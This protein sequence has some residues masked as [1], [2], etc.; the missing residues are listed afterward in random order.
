MKPIGT[1]DL[2]TDPFKKHRSPKPFL[3]GFYDGKTIRI[4]KGPNCVRD[5]YKEMRKFSGYIYA[6]NGGKFDF[7][8]LLPYLYK[9]GAE[10]RPI[11]GRAARFILPN[12][13]EFRDSYC[14][15]PVPLKAT[16]GKLEMDYRKLEANVRHKHMD[17]IVTYLKADLLVLHEKVTEFVSEYGFGMTLAGRT[18]DQFK[19]HFNLNP[20]KTNEFYDRKFRQYYYGGRVEFFELGHLRGKFKLIDINSAYPAAMMKD[21]A[22]GTEW[23]DLTRL[24]KTGVEQCFIRFIGESKGGLPWRGEDKSLSFAPRVGEFFVSGW[25]FVAAQKARAV[26][27]DEYISILRPLETRNFSEFVTHFYGMKKRAEKGSSDELF[28]KLILNSSY[29]RFA[30]NSR[31]YRDVQMESAAGEPDENKLFRKQIAKLVTRKFPKLRGDAFK[32]KCA[33]YWRG[34]EG[35]WELTNKFEDVGI[36]VWER[37]SEVKSDAFFNVATA[38][39]I[40]GAVRAF[41]FESLRA[42][43]RPVYCDTDS[44]ICED[45]GKLKLG[46]ELGEWK[47]E[48]ESVTD[49]LWIAAKK[50]YALKIKNG[51][52]PWKLASKGVRLS[53]GEIKKVAEGETIKTTLIAPTFSIFT[54]NS[55]KGNKTDF[56]TRTTR[57]DDKRIRK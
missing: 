11:K 37:P 22:F 14:I 45:T 41:M 52:K 51:K 29:G 17:E 21:H 24:P 1:F 40:T 42:V 54:S 32:E 33:S 3:A 34:L 39:S 28:A 50:L 55:I 36:S 53:A 56:V 15:L 38:A 43:K 2:E 35:K 20:P 5:C 27:V 25:E 49:G 31:D 4:W 8:Y 23:E 10:L 7:R 30:L 6:H 46:V 9:D 12:K 47:L 26:R 13:T 48:C 16:G 44:I 57:R 19:K 18:F